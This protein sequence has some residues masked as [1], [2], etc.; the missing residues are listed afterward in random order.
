MY[1]RYIPLLIAVLFFGHT[2]SAHGQK[3]QNEKLITRKSVVV[4]NDGNSIPN[5]I[6]SGKE[7]AIEVQ[8]D[9]AGIFS[10]SVPENSIILIEAKGYYQKMFS[11]LKMPEIV[12]LSKAPFLMEEHN[13][14][15]VAFGQ[16]KE[17]ETVGAISTIN[18]KDILVT[19]NT[20]SVEKAI[21]GRLTGLLNSSNI[22]GLG[23]SLVIIDGV[24]RDLSSINMEEVEQI[25]VLKDA[26]ASVLY[27]TQAKNGVILITTKRG[28]A[29]K[30]KIN[31]TMERGLSDPVVLPKYL[32]SADYMTLYNEA[33]AN[34]GL[35]AVYS[36]ELISNYASG[37]N[38]YRYPDVDYYSNEFLRS[39]KSFTKF[40]SEFSGGNESAQYYANL[41]WINSGSLF[42]LG[43]GKHASANRINLRANVD[44]RIND[45]IKTHM[46]AIAIFDFNKGPNG[47]FWGNSAELHPYYFAPLIPISMVEDEAIKETAKLVNG[48][49]IL[50]GTSQYQDN[51]YGNMMFSGYNQAIRRTVQFN[52]GIDFDLRNITEGLTFKTYISFDIYNKFNQSVNNSYAIYQPVWETIDGADV[53]TALTK[54]GKDENSGVQS[55]S[56]PDYFRKTGAYA[57]FNYERT[58][59]EVHSVTGTLLGYY[60]SL[61][62]NEVIVDDK[63][64]HIGLRITYDNAKKYLVDFSAAYV[65]SIKLAE[66]NRAALSPTLGLA[67]IVSEE[68][69]LTNNKSIDYLKVRLSAGIINSD[70]DLE[71][72]GGSNYKM[73][74]STFLTGYTYR[75]ADSYRSNRSVYINRYANPNL[76][77]EK[78]KNINLGIEGY[79]F[80]RSIYIEADVFHTINSG[81]VIQRVTYPGYLSRYIPYE[82]YDANTYSG[83]ELGAVWFKEI[84]DFS[85]NLGGNLLYAT[86]SVITKDE[87]WQNEYQHREGR[88]ADALFGLESLGFFQDEADI[89]GS[90]RQVFGEV[91]PGDIKYKDQ[92]ND[93]IVDQNDAIE[94]GNW[95]ARISYALHLTLKYKSFSLFALGNG[96]NGGNSYYSGNYFWVDGNSKYSEEV[97][98]RW[99]S[100]TSETA[101]YPRLTTHSSS[102]NYRNSTFWIYDANYFTLS[103][104]QLTYELPHSLISN[105]AVKELSVYLR[106][107]NLV[108]FETETEKRQLRIG[109]EPRYR[110]Y[111]LGLRILF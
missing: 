98:N 94:I 105:W 30:R 74:E 109:S 54:I 101:T 110:N 3:K 87:I 68:D 37:D 40:L 36:D 75:W 80:N 12:I 42:N 32:G 63:S 71:N 31:F 104:V 22:R 5:T 19:D 44:L 18:P 111:S 33:C 83:A 23:K 100:E 13:T 102:N 82:N 86:S 41:G 91:R 28:E 34:D 45:Y 49:Y 25:T 108:T 69:F 96:Q 17:K 14:I 43:E 35:P 89:A 64:A 4:D 88:P 92:N 81:K 78:V 53:L 7:G 103:R 93:G 47:D 77:Y 20:Q 15:N 8:T 39:S 48:K 50:G 11:A 90:P 61:R 29:Y 51:V 1:T 27:G 55:L 95:Q 6:I 24:P 58:F 99:T 10:I 26:N 57:M 56:E 52:N 76:T 2:E 97:L 38:P 21:S 72:E 62:M 85:F 66:G 16:I 60:N 46:D 73:Y 106:G 67:W 84:G 79:F 9:S 107:A 70:I 59:K 65:N